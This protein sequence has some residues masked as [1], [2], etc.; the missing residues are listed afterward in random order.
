MK[1]QAPASASAGMP[2]FGRSLPL[3]H[4]IARGLLVAAGLSLPAAPVLAQGPPPRATVAGTA[5]AVPAPRAR[6]R[7]PGGKATAEHGEA[8]QQAWRELAELDRNAVRRAVAN[9]AVERYGLIL[10]ELTEQA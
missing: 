6:A 10:D 3:A 9:R 4:R 8:R 7:R 1:R 5:G 2:T